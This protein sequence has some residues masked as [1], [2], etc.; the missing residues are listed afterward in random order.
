[1]ATKSQQHMLETASECESCPDLCSVINLGVGEWA[2]MFQAD[3]FQRKQW[4]DF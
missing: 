2:W 3:G 1:M 4:K